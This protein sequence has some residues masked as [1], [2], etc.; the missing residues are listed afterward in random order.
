LAVSS[1]L[2]VL[3]SLSRRGLVREVGLGPSTGGRPPTLVELN[4]DANFAV[5]VNVRP[6][7]V[8]A[9]LMDLVGSIRSET[10]LPLQGGRDPGSVGGTVVEGVNQ[11]IRMARV[12]PARVLGVGVGC[13]GP[14][15]DG[16]VVVGIPGFPWNMEPLADQLEHKLGL[17]VI[18]ENDANCGALAEFR[19][20]ACARD[21]NCSSMVYLYVDHGVGAG[22]V[23]DGNVYRGADGTAGEIGH[24]VVDVD[25]PLCVCG[26][27]GCL[28]AVASVESIVRRTVTASKLG[29]STDLA[30]RAGGDWDSVSFEVVMEAVEAEDAIG[31]TALD[32]ALNFLAIGV[33]N[34][35]RT[36]R[37]TTI[38]LGGYLFERGC[39]IYER[40]QAALQR[41]PPL[42]GV[43]P[44]QV[45]LGVLGS[46]ACCVGAGTLVLE[47]FFGVAQQVMAPMA[48]SQLPEPA[49]E[50]TLVWPRLAEQGIVLKPSDVRIAWAGDLQP[51]YSRVRSGEPISVTVDVRLE[52]ADEDQA[53]SLKALLHWDRV[54]L[55]GGPWATPKNSPMQLISNR[56]GLLTY[57]VTLGSLPPGRYEYAAHVM[58]ANDIWIRAFQQEEVRNGRV[59]VLHSRAVAIDPGES[60]Q[61]ITRI[62]KE[63][64]RQ[65]QLIE[66]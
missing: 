61:N 3:S 2:N 59:E 21:E 30:N 49:F 56:Y 41:R 51:D 9:I 47:N 43:T 11:V 22:M 50:H 12:D 23:I 57:G 25:G 35:S 39:G 13:P 29:G 52:K 54:A 17:P 10:L 42:F 4:P 14:I 44:L 28:E 24:T 1:I 58:G 16:R 60:Q 53:A 8:E 40:L 20:G 19:H 26:N 34:L 18:V 64:D 27:Y 5:G 45:E 55:F 37:P 38:V 33:T 66:G 7:Y 31:V 62:R 65:K 36:F 15:S 63:A 6:A 46:K 48:A 32:E